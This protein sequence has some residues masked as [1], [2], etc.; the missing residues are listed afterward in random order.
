MVVHMDYARRRQDAE[1]VSGAGVAGTRLVE[2][3]AGVL[4]IQRHAMR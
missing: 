2:V 1:V 4:R 3:A